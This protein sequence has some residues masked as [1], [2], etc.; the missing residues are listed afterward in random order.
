M[1]AMIERPRWV[2]HWLIE[3]FVGWLNGGE[4]METNVEDA[5]QSAAVIFG[6]IESSRTGQSV[7]VQQ[8]LKDTKREVATAP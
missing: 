1:V 6:A 2:H 5:L 4:P 7:K 3:Q 8:L